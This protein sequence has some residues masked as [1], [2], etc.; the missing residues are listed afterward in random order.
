MKSD[1]TRVVFFQVSDATGKL[2]W[3]VKMAQFHFTKKEHLLIVAEEDR[4][5]TFTDELLWKHLPES[6]LPHAI[7]DQPCF[8][9]I[10]LTKEKKNLNQARYAFNLCPTPLLIEGPFRIIYDFEDTS[11]QNKK[12][13][14]QVRFDAYK[15]ASYLIESRVS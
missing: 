13:L 3:I 9:W 15:Q 4:A 11:S 2:N 8:E 6:F 1:S 5:L 12:N 7:V 10:A 14:S